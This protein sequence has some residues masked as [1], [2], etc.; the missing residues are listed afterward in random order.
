MAIPLTYF[1]KWSGIRILQLAEISLSAS[2]RL[3]IHESSGYLFFIC[4]VFIVMALSLI[5]KKF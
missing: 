4:F 1:V 3:R 2:N 5:S